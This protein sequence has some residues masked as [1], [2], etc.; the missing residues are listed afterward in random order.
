MSCWEINKGFQSV[1]GPGVQGGVGNERIDFGASYTFVG[2]AGRDTAR[3]AGRHF[4]RHRFAT[5]EPFADIDMV[6]V[7]V[8]RNIAVFTC[9]GLFAPSRPSQYVDQY[10]LA[11]E[12]Q[13]QGRVG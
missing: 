8:V 7:E 5:E 6:R 4:G 13:R 11:F 9:P 10:Q 12:M 2:F 3:S 1:E